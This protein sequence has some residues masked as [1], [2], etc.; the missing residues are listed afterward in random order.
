MAGV[1]PASRYER[2]GFDSCCLHCRC[3][4]WPAYTAPFI[5][6]SKLTGA[7]PTSMNS[8]TVGVLLASSQSAILD[9]IPPVAR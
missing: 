3:S 5:I 6:I 7:V 8:A 4:L 2:G 1:H 9:S